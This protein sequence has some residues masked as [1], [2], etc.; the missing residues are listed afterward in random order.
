[1]DTSDKKLG[2]GLVILGDVVK[3]ALFQAGQSLAEMSGREISIEGPGLEIISLQKFINLAGGP[4]TIV[5]AV[6][7][8]VSGDF[9]GHLMLLIPLIQLPELIQMILG[10][11]DSNKT[12]YSLE[13][14]VCRSLLGELGN[15]VGT[16]FLNVM[17]NKLEMVMLPSIPYVINDYAGSI[18]SSLALQASTLGEESWDQLLV[19]NTKLCEMNKKTRGFLLLLPQPGTLNQFLNKVVANKY[20]TN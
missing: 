16:S 20:G 3:Q 9:K 17:G 15:I 1:M 13:D 8:A 14:E 19:V 4:D 7:L 6:Y 2:M 11:K 5:A 18:L 10:E 12:S